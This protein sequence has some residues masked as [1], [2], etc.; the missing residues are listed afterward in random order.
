[1]IALCALALSLAT[2]TDGMRFEIVL[3]ASV[4]VG[5]PVPITLRLTNTE[6][7]RVT[8]YLQGRP[9]AFD[10]TVRRL[11]GT[12][13]WRRLEGEVVSAIL[14]VRH[15]E[16]GASLEFAEVWRQ[17]SNTGED[18]P[19]GDY[20]VTGTLPTD[21]PKPLQSSAAVLRILP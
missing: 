9:I 1:M 16:P 7:E 11:D 20:R 17:V 5:E 21:A 10:L 19:P 8:V 13:V 14:A 6:R 2:A 3:P 4:H 15:V 18:V 12:L